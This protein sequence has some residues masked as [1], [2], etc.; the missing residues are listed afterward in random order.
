MLPSPLTRL[1]FLWQVDLNFKPEAAMDD[2]N[3][4][5]VLKDDNLGGLNSGPGE[6]T[7]GVLQEQPLGF[8]CTSCKRAAHYLCLPEHGTEYPTEVDEI[9]QYWQT[10]WM[11]AECNEL[12]E[13]EIENILAWRKKARKTAQDALDPPV[14][15][16]LI[17]S[18]RDSHKHTRDHKEAGIKLPNWKDQFVEAEYL[19]KYQGFSYTDCTWVSHSYVHIG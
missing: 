14:P 16:E 11:C 1:T 15:R 6:I 9:A 7:K 13:I 4:P 5:P 8:R 17:G 3:S 10:D 18:L 2:R 12:A 19:C